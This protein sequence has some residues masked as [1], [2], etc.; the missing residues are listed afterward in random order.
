[1][2]ISSQTVIVL[3]IMTYCAHFPLREMTDDNAHEEF[4]LSNMG[5]CT[6]TGCRAT[7]HLGNK[8]VFSVFQC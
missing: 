2:P 3:D 1:M 7:C 5:T 6:R 4:Q 8:H